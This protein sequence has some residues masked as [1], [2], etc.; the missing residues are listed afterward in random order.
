MGNLTFCRLIVILSWLF[1]PLSVQGSANLPLNISSLKAPVPVPTETDNLLVYE[2]QLV[3]PNPN[4]IQVGLIE[5]TDQEG[6]PLVTYFG[7]Q[8]ADNSLV[9]DSKGRVETK[10]ILLQKDMGT[11]IYFYVTLPKTEKI[12]TQLKNKIW[13][14]RQN[15]D[16]SEVAIESQDFDLAVSDEKPVVIGHPLKGANWVAAGALAPFS[17]HRRT[18]LPIEGNF[19]LAQRYAVDWEQICKDGRSVHGSVFDNNNWNAFGHEVLAVADGVVS[20]IHQGVAENTPPKLPTATLKVADITGN[21]IMLKINQNGKDYYILYAHM[22]PGSI[23]VKEGEKIKQGQ[24]IGLVGNTGNSSAPH[25]HIHVCDA[26]DPLKSE[27]VPFVLKDAK[28][29]GTLDEINMDYGV[30][31]PLNHPKSLDVKD[32]IPLENEL[33][34]FTEESSVKCQKK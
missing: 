34:D 15:T 9:Y 28:V 7:H 13:F 11:F 6:K 31:K 8:L 19:Y 20:K 25:L 16:K 12:P 24:V 29:Q 1:I 23:R 18:I 5:V 3:N 33:I 30:W 2:L 21:S 32:K 26:N 14:S 4:E 10:D 27:G 17:Y 22:Q